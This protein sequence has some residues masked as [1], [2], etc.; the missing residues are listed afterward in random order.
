MRA[1]QCAF[2]QR[3]SPTALANALLPNKCAQ[4]GPVCHQ[5]QTLPTQQRRIDNQEKH[6]RNCT[7]EI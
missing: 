2:T 1:L 4:D 3:L 5:V 7:G 6:S